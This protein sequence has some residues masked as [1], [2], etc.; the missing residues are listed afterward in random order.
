MMNKMSP[1]ES[2]PA[3][4]ATA[5]FLDLIAR[6]KAGDG[7]AFGYLLDHYIGKLYAEAKRLIGPR[8][9]PLVD[10]SDLIQAT[11]LVLWQG[12]RKDKFIVDSPRRFVSLARTVLRR[13]A[14]RVCRAL[15]PELQ[16]GLST[17]EFRISDTM[18]DLA[19][20]QA[21]NHEQPGGNMELDDHVERLYRILDKV[22]REVVRLRLLGYTTVRVAQELG[23]PAGSLR[24][25]LMRLR[26]RLTQFGEL[27][28]ILGEQ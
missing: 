20:Y 27:Q 16:V 7:A 3:D 4:L 28:R 26:K 17:M 14:A 19:I 10:P 12:L 23:L 13:Q 21:N 6:A 8:L 9:Q 2:P 5:D 11:R 25:R 15:K 22:D 1:S 24:V 18:S